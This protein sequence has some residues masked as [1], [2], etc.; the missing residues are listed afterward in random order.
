MKKEIYNSILKKIS[1]AAPLFAKSV[2]EK[3]VSARGHTQ[4]SI[5]AAEMLKIL[6]NEVGPKLAKDKT[7]SNSI[8]LSGAALII[9]NDCE[10]VVYKNAQG[11]VL[12][13]ELR[14]GNGIAQNDFEVFSEKGIV[15]KIQDCYQ[16]KVRVISLQDKVYNVSISPN[17]NS[18]G[19]ITGTVSVV[20]DITLQREIEDEVVSYMK[21]LKEEV[22]RR[23]SSEKELKESQ[24]LILQS[25]RMASL[26]EMASGI[27]HEINNPLAMIGLNIELLYRFLD[28]KRLT[29]DILKDKLAK[30]VEAGERINNII[31]GMKRLTRPTDEL[32]F[33]TF[34]V[35]DII[36][37]VLNICSERFKLA[38]INLTLIGDFENIKIKGRDTEI[39]QILVNILNNAHDE[40]ENKYPMPWVEIEVYEEQFHVVIAVT[41]CGPG[42]PKDIENKMFDPFFTTKLHRGGTG[43][44][45][46]FS[47][48]IAESHKGTIIIN[49]ESPNTRIEVKLPKV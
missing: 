44:G 13:S 1:K 19:V 17:F 18:A 31:I 36:H 15:E 40:I 39:G 43:L 46:G 12:L 2:L 5:S 48:K 20:Q 24:E 8:L 33:E 7:Q 29:D 37:N 4:E 6:S 30:I 16:I 41:D 23:T 9:T 42:I 27:A 38:N 22:I 47:R 32:D 49:K 21:N 25:S 11:E 28:K 3:A 14:S 45:L 26:G 35:R 10:E 34:L